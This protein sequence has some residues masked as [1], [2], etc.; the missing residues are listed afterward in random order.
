MARE[1]RIGDRLVGDG[2]PTFVVAEIG[3]NHNGDVNIAR[4]LIDV[5]VKYG[6]DAVK[7]QNVRP[8]C[9]SCQSSNQMRETPWGTSLPDYRYKTEFGGRVSRDRPPLQRGG[10]QWFARYGMSPADFMEQ[11]DTPI[12]PGFI[13]R[14]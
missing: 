11:F 12:R 1:V 8:S 2:Y 9:A 4:Q 14:P 5:A 10:I 6:V 7:F 13:D 3:I